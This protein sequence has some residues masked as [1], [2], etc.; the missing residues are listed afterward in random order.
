MDSATNIGFWELSII[1]VVIASWI[2]YRYVAPKG[3]REWSRAGLIQAFIIALYAEMY[4][5]PLTIYLL[6]GW[7]GLDIPWV[8]ESGHLWAA[9]FGWGALGAIIEML[10][11][12]TLVFTGLSI[13]VEGWREVYVATKE[14]RLATDKLYSVVRH[15]QYTGIFLAV[16][17]QLIH[18]PTIP[19]LVLFP[20]I[21]WAYYRLSLR[22]EQQMIRQF[23]SS[24]ETYQ[25]NIPMFFPKRGEWRKLIS[26]SEFR[27]GEQ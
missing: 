24:Y 25:Q 10:V 22:E 15:P 3:W 2:L 11:G 6:T 18:W 4:G 14:K 16:F 26:T 19:T 21:V 7:L 8:H 5:F 12:Y 23:G 1:M 9:V 27:E 13:L 20:V 17:G